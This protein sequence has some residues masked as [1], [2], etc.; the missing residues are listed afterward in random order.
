MKSYSKKQAGVVFANVKNGKLS[1]PADFAKSLYAY[2]DVYAMNWEQFEIDMV[3]AIR[4]TVSAIFAGDMEEAQN[5][6]DRF[7]GIQAIHFC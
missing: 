3:N 7:Y 4:D 6:L 5:K 1:A 2:A